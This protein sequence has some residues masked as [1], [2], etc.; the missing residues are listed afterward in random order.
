MYLSPAFNWWSNAHLFRNIGLGILLVGL[1][2]VWHGRS[3]NWSGLKMG[4]SKCI[5]CAAALLLVA[6]FTTRIMNVG[7][8]K[9]VFL[10]N[11]LNLKRTIWAGQALGT[12]KHTIVFDYKPDELGLGKSGKGVLSVD[13]KEVAKNSMEHGTPI[14]FPEDESFD[15]GSDTRTGGRRVVDPLMIKTS[16][17]APSAS[18]T[19]T[20]LNA[21]VSIPSRLSMTSPLASRRWA[22][23][24]DSG[25]HSCGYSLSL[26]S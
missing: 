2:P 9:P 21:T 8:G 3:K 20:G 14:T 22:A 25:R 16:V 17:A 15:I 24:A 26:R 5:V 11:L 13:G 19:S 7:R 12:G 18:A 4:M 10:Y 6:V 1:W 23:P